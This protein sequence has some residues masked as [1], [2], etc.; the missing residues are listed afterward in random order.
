MPNSQAP[1]PDL[2]ANPLRPGADW[3]QLVRVALL[4]TRQSPDALPTVPGLPAGPETD[5]A[6]REKHLLQAAGALSLIRKA[7]YLPASSAGPAVPVAPAETQA[8]LGPNGAQALNVLLEGQYADLL[9]DFLTALAEHQRRVPHPQL[10]YL[11]EHA[12]TRPALQP[13]TAAVLGQRGQWLAAQNPAW[14]PILAAST[15]PQSETVWETGTLP[16]RVSYLTSLR[17]QQPEQ[18]RELLAATLP[19]EPAKTQAALLA[20][21]RENASAADAELLG[22]YLG[23]KSKEVRQTVLPQLARLSGNPLPER[24]WQRAEP[25]VQLKKG[26]LNKKLMVELPTTDWDKTWLLD[27]IEQ[28]DARFQGEKAAL[29]GQ[30]LALIPPQLWAKQ[31]DLTAPKILELVAGTE[32]AALLLT[33]WAEATLLHQDTEWATA[34]LH[35]RQPR[36]NPVPLPLEGL[37]RLLTPRQM[38]ELVLPQLSATSYFGPDAHWLPLLMLVPGPWPERLTSRVVEL[39][40]EALSHPERLYRIQ[41]ATSQLLEHM[42]RVVP[43]TQ[44]DLCAQPLQPLLQDV[45]YLHN[46]LARLL[47]TLHFRQQLD[48]ALEEPPGPG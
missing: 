17:R 25:L 12:R 19:Q 35:W 15:L 11:L 26:L 34:L 8:T 33:A 2:A 23:S 3:Q 4:G 20:T 21:L 41:Y 45:P 9:P 27:G 48:A 40:R 16:Q 42:A 13:A 10:V 29:L 37:A 44:Y 39:L 31:W 30:L 38:A 36:K 1:T 46:S 18:A 14:A 24:L 7:G 5:E 43:A 22:Q 6:S 28:R 47:N 32:W